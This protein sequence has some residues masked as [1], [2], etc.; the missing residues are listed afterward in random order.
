MALPP[1]AR[2]THRSRIAARD[3]SAAR[4]SAA[5]LW[6]IGC[7]TQAPAAI[8]KPLAPSRGSWRLWIELGNGRS[9]YAAGGA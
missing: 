3:R 7:S 2:R 6:M 9:R 5:E 4:Q 8:R 1:R